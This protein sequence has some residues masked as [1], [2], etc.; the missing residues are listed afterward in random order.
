MNNRLQ[1]IDDFVDDYFANKQ[2]KELEYEQEEELEY[3]QKNELIRIF[4][5]DKMNNIDKLFY[6][7][8]DYQ[9]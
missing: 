8:I 4:D 7:I 1:E 5:I 6:I 2:E 9:K 3:D